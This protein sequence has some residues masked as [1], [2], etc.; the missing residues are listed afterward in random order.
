MR[1]FPPSSL[2]P[3]RMT[4]T[5]CFLSKNM[6]NRTSFKRPLPSVMK[7]FLEKLAPWTSTSLMISKK[8]M[9]K[10]KKTIRIHMAT[11]HLFSLLPRKI[12]SIKVNNWYY[13]PRIEITIKDHW[14]KSQIITTR[15]RCSLHKKNLK[16][17]R[18]M[19][20]FITKWQLYLLV[21][22]NQKSRLMRCLVSFML[23]SN[24][25]KNKS[26]LGKETFSQVHLKVP[27]SS[28]SR[29]KRP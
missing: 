3:H 14:S 15:K 18:N 10:M 7:T 4:K 27:N 12:R 23:N 20:L 1:S 29:Y 22:S 2:T 26:N 8:L 24:S 28:I 11:L 19:I 13:H 9:D 25:L 16:I 21:T 5:I 6:K 17:K